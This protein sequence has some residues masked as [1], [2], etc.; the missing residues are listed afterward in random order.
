MSMILLPY[1]AAACPAHH[2][3]LVSRRS[4]VGEQGSAAAPTVN[5]H[6]QIFAVAIELGLAG[7]A[8][9]LAM[10]AAHCFLFHSP[11]L[12]GWIG[13][14][15]VFQNIISSLTSPHLF[16]FV[17]GWLYMLGGMILRRRATTPSSS[18]SHINAASA[19]VTR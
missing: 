3:L 5:P 8:L 7:T 10:R 2:H 6:S 12:T 1:H 13:T 18:N 19:A 16:D 17:H 9:L 4:T 15:V 11:D 14:V